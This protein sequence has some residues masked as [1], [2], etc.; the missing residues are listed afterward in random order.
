MQVKRRRSLGTGTVEDD[1]KALWE[2]LDGARNPAGLLRVKIKEMEEGT[3]RGTLTPDRDIEEMAK[4][5]SLDA[6]ASAKLSEVL[7]K[8]DNRAKD[9]RQISKHLELSNKPSS[10]VMLMLKDLRAGKTVQ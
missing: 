9:I 5:F 6:Q 1:C 8:R 3:F 7:A 10:L 2:I 4:R